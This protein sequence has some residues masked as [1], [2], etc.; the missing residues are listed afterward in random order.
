MM[1]MLFILPQKLFSFSRY[2]SFCLDFLVMYQ[3]GLI[4]A[5]FKFL[6]V[7]SWLTTIV[8]HI[9]PNISK[10]LIL[11]FMFALNNFLFCAF[12][13]MIY[14]TSTEVLLNLVAP[15]NSAVLSLDFEQINAFWT[16]GIDSVTI[17]F[18]SL[19]VSRS[20]PE[21]YFSHSI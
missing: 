21:L 15:L 16:S 18:D 14:R 5:N 20:F 13:T 17:V 7:T 1:K 3:K 4:K 19:S 9:L 10:C 6:D 2:S 11:F 12:I 8:I